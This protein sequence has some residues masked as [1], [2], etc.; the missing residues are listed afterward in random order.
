MK[1]AIF[2]A[3]KYGSTA[4]YA[5]WIS[6]ATGLP[7]FDVKSEY[8]DPMN[9]DFLVL[10]SPILYYK[11]LNRRWIES[12]W[13]KIKN[14]P[15][16]LFSVSGAGAGNKLDGWISNS[17]LP[18]SFTLKVKHVALKGRQIPE[19]LSFYDRVMLRIAAMKNPDPQASKEEREGFDYMDKNSIEPV[20]KLIQELQSKKV[21]KTSLSADKIITK[22]GSILKS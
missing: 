12:H 16:I 22:A 10:G 7:V 21:E 4:Q 1:G 18:L 13:S 3:S 14:K 19:E 9:Y 11:L 17:D 8:A 5:K 6:E 2:Y 15:M 20:V